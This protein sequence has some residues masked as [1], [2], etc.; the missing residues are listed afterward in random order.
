MAIFRYTRRRLCWQYKILGMVEESEAEENGDQIVLLHFKIRMC[1]RFFAFIFKASVSDT[2]DMFFLLRVH[3]FIMFFAS[4]AKEANKIGKES[5]IC[6]EQINSIKCN[7]FWI[8]NNP[9]FWMYVMLRVR[10]KTR[11]FDVCINKC[12]NKNRSAEECSLPASE[13]C[14]VVETLRVRHKTICI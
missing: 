8:N 6:M 7:V 4:H 13:L 14:S 11:H 10:L 12:R 5:R 1:A 9:I 3:L 2:L